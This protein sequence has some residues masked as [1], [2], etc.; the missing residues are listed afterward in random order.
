MN[1]KEKPTLRKDDIFLRPFIEQDIN[2]LL[3]ILTMPN[4]INLTGSTE[5]FLTEKVTLSDEEKEK[6]IKWYQTRNE[7]TDRL[8]LA[9]E[10]EAVTVGEVVINLYDEKKNQANLRILISD[11]Y[12]GKGIGTKALEAMTEYIFKETSLSA[13]TLDVF[14]FNPKA[15]HVYEKIGF[16]AFGRLEAEAII[17]DK[18]YDSIEM[19]L[20]REKWGQRSLISD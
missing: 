16:E 5:T 18:A 12:A 11:D 20:T 10:F 3:N 14:E 2:V 17:D 19:I 8:D 4:V 7:Q 13:L 6:T 9:I 1:V 15:K